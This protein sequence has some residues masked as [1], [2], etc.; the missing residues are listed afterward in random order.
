MRDITQ[1]VIDHG[2]SITLDE[3]LEAMAE[4]GAD[5]SV[6]RWGS[7]DTPNAIL[8]VIIGDKAEEA[9]EAVNSVFN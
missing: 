1:D 3:L 4:V 5:N 9:L 8:M 6:V 2:G 7:L